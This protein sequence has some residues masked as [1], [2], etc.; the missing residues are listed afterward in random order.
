MPIFVK[1]MF[2]N[3]YTKSG[4]FKREKLTGKIRIKTISGQNVGHA[5]T[6]GTA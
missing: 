3:V 1:D 6:D 4:L 5:S 2:I